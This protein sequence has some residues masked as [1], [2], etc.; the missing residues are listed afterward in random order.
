MRRF[1]LSRAALPASSRI[2]ADRYSS[3]A[4]RYTTSVS[5]SEGGHKSGKRGTWCTGADTAAESRFSQQT[6]DTAN[7]ELQS[8]FVR[9]GPA[10]S[11]RSILGFTAKLAASGTRFCRHVDRVVDWNASRVDAVFI[12]PRTSRVTTRRDATW[13]N[14]HKHHVRG[15]LGAALRSCSVI[16]AHCS[17][18]HRRRAPSSPWPRNQL[19]PQAE[20][21]L[22][23]EPR[24]SSLPKP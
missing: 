5:E 23:L 22:L 18:H 6:M 21:P 16:D 19:P 3:T 2:S 17:N 8:R 15:I 10:F 4:A 13:T 24:P 11:L 7:R 9:A 20:R 12:P 1:L 14:K